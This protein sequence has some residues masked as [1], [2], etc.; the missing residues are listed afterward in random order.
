MDSDVVTLFST[1]AG[2]NSMNFNNI[3][4]DDYNFDDYAP[5]T[6]NHVRLLAWCYRY[7]RDKA[8]KKNSI[9]N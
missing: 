6:I 8:S 9:K 3:N 2:L 1:D 5:K 7:K 4:L